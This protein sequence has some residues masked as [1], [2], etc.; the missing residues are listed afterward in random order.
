MKSWWAF[1]LIDSHNYVNRK[2]RRWNAAV[3]CKTIAWLDKNNRKIWSYL[4]YMLQ[5]T[6]TQKSNAK[7]IYNNNNKKRRNESK[8]RRESTECTDE[9]EKNVLVSE[10]RIMDQINLPARVI[11]ITIF[12]SLFVAERFYFAGCLIHFGGILLLLRIQLKDDMTSLLC[13]FYFPHSRMPFFYL[14]SFYRFC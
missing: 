5:S 12:E 7:I 6:S 13:L 9:S 10:I 3:Y 8:N 14:F 2:K 11:S 1:I 4:L